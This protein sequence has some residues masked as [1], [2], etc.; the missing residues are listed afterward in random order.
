MFSNLIS[1]RV[2]IIFSLITLVVFLYSLIPRKETPPQLINSTPTSGVKNFSTIGSLIFKYDRGISLGDFTVTSVPE[3]IWTVS[4]PSE[5]QLLVKPQNQLL[6]VTSYS[7]TINWQGEALHTH[8]L[9]TEDTQTDYEVIEKV[10]SE[11]EKNY[12]LASKIPYEQPGFK[13][14]YQKEL[15]LEI[16]LKNSNL[17]RDIIINAV[18]DWV[19]ENGLDPDSHTYTFSN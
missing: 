11:I 14:Q 17:E 1:K 16:I 5:K 9:T 10:K 19:K 6:R 2:I 13:V 8:T 4:K 12:P 15:V 18:R 3:A 7:L